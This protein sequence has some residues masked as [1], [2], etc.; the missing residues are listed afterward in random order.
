VSQAFD[1]VKIL[2][3]SQVFAGPFAVMQLALLGAEVVKVEQPIVGDQA[4]KLM[5][6]G[7]DIGMSPSFMGMNVNK[8]SITLNL[9]K[10]QAIEI[11]KQLAAQADVLVENFKA[12]T[13]DRYGLGYDDIKAINPGIIY[14]SVTGYGQQGPK[15][16]EAAYDA[17]IQAAS[18]MMS[19]NGHD[20]TGP[21][22]TGYMQVDMSTSL[23]AAFAIS[24]SLHRKAVT[25]LGQQ[26]DVAM[27]DTAIMLQA[28]QY[29]NYLI[30]GT[31]DG[32]IGNGSPTGQP[33][34]NVF[35][36]GD[37][38]I[39]IT[40]IQKSQVEKMF[41]VFGEP[42]ITDQP[43]F[44]SNETR[45]QHPEKIRDLVCQ[46]L[47]KNTTAH[48]MVELSKAGVPVAEVRQIPDVVADP[49]FTY[50]NVFESMPSPISD[51]TDTITVVKAGYTTNV[52]G[53]EIR[54]AAPMLGQDTNE[55]LAGLGYDADT[56]TELRDHDVL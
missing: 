9:R 53:P 48:W 17:A 4:R 12:G 47:A 34:A 40:A 10:P 20:A 51:T 36:T 45:R 56:I 29:N 54:H 5:N 14:C 8:K 22:R 25:G 31:L 3:F 42:Q 27:I 35:P 16:G 28:A 46:A 44:A 50:R 52:D 19:I 23:N 15:A 55:I 38:F 39:Q 18:G 24:A 30:Q 1:G 11:A 13:M 33:T 43:E 49:Q 26:V 37:G 6:V 32:L 41:A 21:T 2:D 7:E